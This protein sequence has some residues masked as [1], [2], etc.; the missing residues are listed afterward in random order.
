M[1]YKSVILRIYHD[2][3]GS[4]AEHSER[5]PD[6]ALCFDFLQ[7]RSAFDFFFAGAELLEHLRGGQLVR[8]VD[9]KPGI[10]GNDGHAVGGCVLHGHGLDNIPVKDDGQLERCIAGDDV[11][12]AALAGDP[13]GV[14]AFCLPFQIGGDLLHVQPGGGAGCS[15]HIVKT[16]FRFRSVFRARCAAGVVGRGC[17]ARCSPAKISGFVM[18]G[19][20]SSPAAM[21]SK[22]SC[23]T[24]ASS[25]AAT[26]AG[27]CFASSTAFRVLRQASSAAA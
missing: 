26:A 14:A 21:L 3:P 16:P 27:A 22:S 2:G 1:I 19:H 7:D 24:G 13:N 12:A 5:A 6:F 23:F 18:V 10:T 4:V 8:I 15:F 20:A 11:H 25:G 9:H 17:F